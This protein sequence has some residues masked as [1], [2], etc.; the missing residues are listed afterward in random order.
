MTLDLIDLEITS[1][2]DAK[3]VILDSDLVVLSADQPY[4]LLE[5][6]VNEACS[7]TRIP[8][9]AGGMNVCEGQVYAVV[10]GRTGC[11]ACIDA[12]Y[13]R[14]DANHASFIADFRAS[15]YRMPST[16]IMPNYMMLA[17]MVSGD[18][19]RWFT[20][21]ATMLSEGKVIAMNYDSY[22]QE[23]RID[24]TRKNPDCPVCRDSEPGFRNFP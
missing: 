14:S 20:G 2:A 24:F 3:R 19:A 22:L 17:G 9:I 4:W 15:D 1:A 7:E 11:V 16:S 12:Q 5:R 13:G 23:T 8:F 18:V 10:P 21:T 6:W